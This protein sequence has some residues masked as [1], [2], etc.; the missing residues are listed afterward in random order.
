MKGRLMKPR[1]ITIL[2]CSLL[3]LLSFTSSTHAGDSGADAVDQAV[4]AAKAWLTLCDSGNYAASWEGSAKLF[5]AAVTQEQWQQA[6]NASRR[7]LGSL[8][9]REVKTTQYATSLP[10]APDG[11]YVVIQFTTSFAN[12]RA[13]TE[14]VTPMKD[15]DGT[16]R[17]SGYYIK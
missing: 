3:T 10:G 8:Q 17:V 11:E 12:K 13:A 2:A 15:P 1:A 14:T 16:W 6:L 4:K 9:S 7:P 5:R